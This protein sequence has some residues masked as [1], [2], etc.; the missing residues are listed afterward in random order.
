MFTFG[1]FWVDPNQNPCAP[2]SDSDW[3]L[4]KLI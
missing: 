3:Q 1:K 2:T 4:G